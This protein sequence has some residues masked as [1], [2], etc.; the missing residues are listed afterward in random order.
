MCD[1]FFCVNF[2]WCVMLTYNFTEQFRD[3]KV[4][5][6]DRMTD[7]DLINRNIK[8]NEMVSVNDQACSRTYIYIYI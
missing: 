7:S 4:S 1:E 6:R 5:F 3:T 2:H 8:C